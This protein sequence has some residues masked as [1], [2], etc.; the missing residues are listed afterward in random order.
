MT[1]YQETGFN[2]EQDVK[3]IVSDPVPVATTIDLAGLPSLPNA[4]VG[5]Q[6]FSDA[7][8]ETPA[9][10]GAG[11]VTV[12]V[13][14]VVHGQALVAPPGGGAI[15]A[16]AGTSLSWENLNVKRVN[17]APAGVTTATHWRLVVVFNKG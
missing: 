12:A 13:E 1:D 16:T 3:T 6:F 11:T 10:P 14:S 15:D 2:V 9:T 5:A 7:A 17:A 4:Q 8:G